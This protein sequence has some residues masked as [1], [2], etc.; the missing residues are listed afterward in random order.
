[1]AKTRRITQ[2]WFWS[3]LTYAHRG[4]PWIE[5][6]DTQEI[7]WPYRR[8]RSIVVRI[9]LTLTALVV[10]RWGDPR[11]E[12]E[13]LLHAVRGDFRTLEDLNVRD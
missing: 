9:P 2:R 6:G 12:M 1:M 3:T 10:G 7:E 4:W 5:R 11:P 13:A 8:S